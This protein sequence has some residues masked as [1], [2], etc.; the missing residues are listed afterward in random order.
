MRGLIAYFID[1]AESD[2]PSAPVR[3]SQ[4]LLA[5]VPLQ[6]VGSPYTRLKLAGTD[7]SL[8]RTDKSFKIIRL[9]M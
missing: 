2:I 1:T 8:A 7:C 4:F 6:T 9:H 5:S 3:G